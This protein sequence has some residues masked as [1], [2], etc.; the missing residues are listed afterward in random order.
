MKRWRLLRYVAVA[1]AGAVAL[2]CIGLTILVVAAS[3]IENGGS[4]KKADESVVTALKIA[5]FNGLSFSYQILPAACFLGA[6]IAGTLLARRGELLAAQTMGISPR[7]I[8]F[9]FV[10]VAALCSIIGFFLGAQV[11]P[12]AISSLEQTKRDH[13]QGHVDAMTR[14]YERRV[15]WFRRGDVILHVPSVGTVG[16]TEFAD[17]AVYELVDGRLARITDAASLSFVDDEWLLKDA[18]TIEIS[19]G[20]STHASLRKLALDVRPGDIVE[21]AGDPRQMSFLDIAALIE[22]RDRAGFDSTSHRLEFHN[23]LAY[24]ANAIWMLLIALPWALRPERRRSLAVNL[25]LGVAAIAILFS[26]TYLWRLMALGHHIPA[27]LGVHGFALCC[28]ALIL[29]SDRAYRRFEQRGS[30]F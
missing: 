26:L 29:M 10:G 8:G 23:R 7:L 27:A 4:L 18:T 6:L 19:T 24:P 12:R 14:F 11:V 22:R 1:Y 20:E 17:P 21:V 3:L 16:T 15:E 9:A 28:G 13:M 25:G 5:L 30:L 2:T